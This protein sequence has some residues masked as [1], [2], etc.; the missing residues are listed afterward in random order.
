MFLFQLN[1]LCIVCWPF[2]KIAPLSSGGP[3]ILSLVK[4]DAPVDAKFKRFHSHLKSYLVGAQERPEEKIL[5][6]KHANK[7]L[8]HPVFWPAW[9]AVAVLYCLS[10]LPMST[11]QRWGAGFGR[12]VKKR[13]RSRYKVTRANIQACFP[14]L[15]HE[16]QEQLIDASFVACGRG[17]FETIHA[18]WQDMTPYLQQLKITGGEHLA[19]AQATGKGVFLIGGHYSL[20]DFALPL[21]A[22]QLQKPGYMYRPNDN[23][24]VEW[25]IERGRRRHFNIQ[26]FTK[27]EMK[28]MIAFLKAGG[29]VWYACD[30]DFGHRAKVFVPFFGV[31][32]GCITMP[33]KIAQD[34]GASV[35]FVAH[36]RHPDG[37]YEITFSPV[38]TGFGE[39]ET[40]DAH[41]WMNYIETTLRTHPDQYLWMHKRFKTRPEGTPKLY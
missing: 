37:R 11:K 17:F 40:R 36:L 12:L 14:Q 26:A 33:S 15:D 10:F 5:A 25:M 20:F 28:D 39:D 16:A 1:L 3:A 22:Q 27:H 31:D 41:G 6:K 24:V 29:A 4:F 9:L 21:F 13:M 35:L 7:P 2:A 19:Q 8:W 18:W 30:Q 38:Q 32:A 34:S 23:P